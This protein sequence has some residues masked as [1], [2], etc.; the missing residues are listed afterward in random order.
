MIRWL[1]YILLLIFHI[2]Y[3][4]K[5]LVSTHK[6]HRAVEFYELS[7]RELEKAQAVSKQTSDNSFDSDLVYISHDLAK[8]YI[9][10]GR[11]DQAIR[12]LKNVLHNPPHDIIS[13]RQDVTTLLLI[14]QVQEKNISDAIEALEK[15]YTNQKEIVRKLRSST[16]GSSSAEIIEKEKIILSDIAYQLGSINTNEKLSE[17]L[18]QE[19][20]QQNPH[21]SKAMLGIAKIM[22]NRGEKEQCQN[23]CKKI[24]T[25]VP[26]TEDAAILLSEVLFSTSI[27]DPINAVK[28][29]KELLS[30]NPNNYNVLEKA[31]TLLRRAGQLI[32]AIPLLNAAKLADR[33]C[34]SH[35]GYNYCEGLYARFTNDIVKA[36]LCFNLSRKDDKWGISALTHMIELYLN[37]DQEGVWEEKESGPLDDATRANIAA[38]EELLKELKPKAT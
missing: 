4:G 23:Q 7:I 9:K 25:A 1:L 10:L 28:P 14:T 6:Y 3:I 31:I 34:T 35:P 33:R 19:A 22:L 5:A 37:P 27:D 16:S 12:V 21:N 36:I 15:A 2:N 38:A 8:L 18:Y 32:E 13:L 17:E 26:D 29:L 11:L 24:L 30:M 20:I